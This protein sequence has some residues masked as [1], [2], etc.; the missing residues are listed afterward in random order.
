MRNTQLNPAAEAVDVE[1]DSSDDVR[2]F[3]P[4]PVDALG[5]G[6]GAYVH[7]MSR[8]I[9]VDESISAAAL[10]ATAAGMIGANAHLAL[11]NTWRVVPTV[12]TVIVG[13]SG[14]RKTPLLKN[15]LAPVYATQESYIEQYKRLELTY[16]TNLAEY[17]RDQRAHRARS[18]APRV[19][20]PVKPT[21]TRLVADNATS[22]A[23]MRLLSENSQGIL[24]CVD[25]FSR[26]L[27]GL[28][29]Y[30]KGASSISADLGTY[31]SMFDS[32]MTLSDRVGTGLTHAPIAALS[33]IGG[34]Q[35]GVLK[36]VLSSNLIAS[37]MLARTLL[38]FPTRRRFTPDLQSV[39]EEHLAWWRDLV[40]A[41]V[42]RRNRSVLTSLDGT[43]FDPILQLTTDASDLAQ[44]WLA[45][46]QRDRDQN[47]DAVAS[48]IAKNENYAFKFAVILSLINDPAATT[49]DQA[50]LQEGITIARWFRDEQMRV[51]EMFGI[52]TKLDW[53]LRDWVVARREPVTPSLVAQSLHRYKG[54]TGEARVELNKLWQHGFLSRE[55]HTYYGRD[56]DR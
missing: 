19:S 50:Q 20:R 36:K 18:D 22:E 46:C 7:S 27:G 45:E 56:S 26:L 1:P 9:G 6:A 11:T 40:A 44:A 39:P 4:F 29:R 33:L 43:I 38:V 34:I 13:D 12:W 31:L 52:G 28:D 23:L 55:K 49:V 16:Q 25:E 42:Q 15:V 37:G 10:L 54:K 21:C 41:L 17:E 35:P 3:V 14:T 53:A 51:Y 47:T 30:S 32:T 8:S 24:I 2:P 5:P 48:M